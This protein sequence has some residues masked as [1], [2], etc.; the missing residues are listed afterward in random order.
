MMLRNPI[1]NIGGVDVLNI[2]DPHLEK[3]FGHAFPDRKNDIFERNW[4]IFE[5]FIK[6]ADYQVKVIC[7][8]IFDKSKVDESTLLRTAKILSESEYNIIVLEGNHDSSK[9]SLEKTSF[10]VLVELLSGQDHIRFVRGVETFS[11]GTELVTFIGWE[12]HHNIREQIELCMPQGVKYVYT[13]VDFDSFGSDKSN[14]VP[15]DLFKNYGVE[16]IINGHEH[17]PKRT[18]VGGIEYIGTGSML[19][20]DRSQQH[21]TDKETYADLFINVYSGDVDSVNNFTDKFVYY[22]DVEFNDIPDFIG[23]YGVITKKVV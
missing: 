11:I 18:N 5:H 8:D 9:T 6:I 3:K 10:D 14:T 4:G 16:Y 23:A 13:H 17:L 12:Y 1:I 21:D 22:H 20:H 2:G 19:P 15:F 7:G